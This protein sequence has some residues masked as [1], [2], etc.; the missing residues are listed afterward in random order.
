M[1]FVANLT[2]EISE[3]H[4][5]NPELSI[6]G[7]LL[8]D[9]ADS[10]MPRRSDKHEAKSLE[11]A[12]KLLDESGYTSDETAYI[13]TEIIKP[14]SCN[15]V[16]PTKIE[17][18]VMAA[19]DGAAHFLTDFY[20]HFCW[21]HYGPEDDFSVFKKWVLTKIEKDF[22]KKLFFDDIRSQ[23]RPQ[24]EAVKLMFSQ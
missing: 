21:Q 12:E 20:L 24:Y 7:A 9:I 8:H 18:K 13:I 6:A 14:H 16:L 2:K 1:L 11:I 19:A 10:E 3:K 4:D 22:T 5:A 23:V 17:G 15:P